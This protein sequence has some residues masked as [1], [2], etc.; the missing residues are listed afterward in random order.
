MF[1]TSCVA[2]FALAS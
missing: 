1:Y 2:A